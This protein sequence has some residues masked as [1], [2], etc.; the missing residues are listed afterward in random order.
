MKGVAHSA[1]GVGLIAGAVGIR[2]DEYAVIH[3]K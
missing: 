3:G 1:L 2:Y